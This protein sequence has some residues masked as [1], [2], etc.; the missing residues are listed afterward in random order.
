[1]T[2]YTTPV[3][4]VLRFIF[5]G[6]NLCILEYSAVPFSIA[7]QDYVLRLILKF[8]YA[9]DRNPIFRLN[10]QFRSMYLE[11]CST[12]TFVNTVTSSYCTKT[13]STSTAL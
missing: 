2:D 13:S 3:L 1:M 7:S 5:L 6:I 10:H 11:H 12:T 9:K 4:Q 8:C